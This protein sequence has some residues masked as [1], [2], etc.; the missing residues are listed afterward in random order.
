MSEHSRYKHSLLDLCGEIHGA[1]TGSGDGIPDQR[2]AEIREWLHWRVGSGW[3]S[4]TG[5]SVWLYDNAVRALCFAAL[6]EL[7][8]TPPNVV[9]DALKIRAVQQIIDARDR[10]E[11]W[12]VDPDLIL[13]A[14]DPSSLQRET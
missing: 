8:A 14:L 12:P 4:A 5:V 1:F 2:A 13:A 3:E 7:D 9:R 6:T 10:G 11:A